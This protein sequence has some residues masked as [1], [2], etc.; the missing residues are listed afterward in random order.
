MMTYD[1]YAGFLRCFP[2]P[3]ERQARAEQMAREDW[4]RSYRNPFPTHAPE[5][6]QYDATYYRE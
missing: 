4:T 3:A 1:D 5:H 2:D 6:E